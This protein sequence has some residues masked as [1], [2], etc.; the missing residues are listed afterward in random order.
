MTTTM[1]LFAIVPH[2][3]WFRAPSALDEPGPGCAVAP[4]FKQ[5]AG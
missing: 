3:P 1:L 4:P 5:K 2:F